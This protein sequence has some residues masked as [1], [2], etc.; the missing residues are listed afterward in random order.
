MCASPLSP[1]H[2][3]PDWM[4]GGLVSRQMMH[5]ALPSAAIFGWIGAGP[6]NGSQGVTFWAAALLVSARPED[7]A[8]A[9]ASSPQHALRCSS[10]P[11]GLVF[12]KRNRQTGALVPDAIV[13]GLGCHC[14]LCIRCSGRV[15]QSRKHD[16]EGG[17]SIVGEAGPRRGRQDPWHQ[18]CRSRSSAQRVLEHGQSAS[19]RGLQPLVHHR[20]P[21]GV[22]RRTCTRAHHLRSRR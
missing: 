11:R 19:I 17:E 10:S 12:R 22:S 4:G 5:D 13:M 16:Q 14:S 2:A 15:G 18:N 8:G 7:G 20:T 21:C 9:V 3:Q 1:R 6:T